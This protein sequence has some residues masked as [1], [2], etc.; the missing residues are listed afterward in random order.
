[1]ARIKINALSKDM[2]VSGEELRMV[3]GGDAGETPQ[4]IA[5][6]KGSGWNADISSAG[7]TNLGSGQIVIWNHTDQT[8]TT[9]DM[10]TGYW[11]AHSYGGGE[12]SYIGPLREPTT[13]TVRR[14]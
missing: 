10:G 9:L 2:R 14:L 8:V 11:A 5:S 6:H 3:R 12:V 7:N 13:T 1:M 4:W